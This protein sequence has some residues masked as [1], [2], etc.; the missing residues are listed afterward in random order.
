MH[1]KKHEL[2]LKIRSQQLQPR[3]GICF[4]KRGCRDAHAA[5]VFPYLAAA[6]GCSCWFDVHTSCRNPRFIAWPGLVGRWAGLSSH[7]APKKRHQLRLWSS[8][9]FVSGFPLGAFPH[10]KSVWSWALRWI[11]P[12][13]L[14]PR[15]PPLFP[16]RYL[17]HRFTRL[18]R[19]KMR[20][21]VLRNRLTTGRAYR[22][23]IHLSNK[24]MPFVGVV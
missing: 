15:V 12:A 22:E 17:K 20:P 23:L 6:V 18:S 13:T 24:S 16:H 8:R 2:I 14:W 9:R 21:P 3:C 7:E 5:V 11:W 10:T 1:A 19:P 4:F